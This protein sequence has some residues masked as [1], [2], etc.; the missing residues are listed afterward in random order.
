MTK[1]LSSD[2]KEGTT[3]EQKL[4]DLSKNQPAEETKPQTG[5]V[6]G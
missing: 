3:F 2:A 4:T 6:N 1:V 5:A